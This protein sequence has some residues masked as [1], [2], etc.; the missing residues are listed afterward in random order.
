[1]LLLE[2]MW[3]C[4]RRRLGRLGRAAVSRKGLQGRGATGCDNGA[5]TGSSPENWGSF[6][7]LTLGA[8]QTQGHAAE[9]GMS[10]E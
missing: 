9:A 2:W 5:G 7:L 3:K 10:R 6:S 1:M 8:V 4:G